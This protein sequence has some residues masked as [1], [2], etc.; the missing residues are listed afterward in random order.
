[1]GANLFHLL[2]WWHSLWRWSQRNAK[3]I[4]K[5]QVRLSLEW[6]R[7]ARLD[8]WLEDRVSGW[9]EFDV[10][11]YYFHFDYMAKASTGN[12]TNHGPKL[13]HVIGWWN[14]ADNCNSRIFSICGDGTRFSKFEQRFALHQQHQENGHRSICE[15]W[16]WGLLVCTPF[17]YINS[18]HLGILCFDVSHKNGR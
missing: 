8:S 16:L 10:N 9:G 5:K 1:M 13:Y 2:R 7:C 11:Y 6:K 3:W 15:S 18:S 4:S 17:M 12:N 14:I